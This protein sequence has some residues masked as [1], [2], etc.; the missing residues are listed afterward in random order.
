MTVQ[1]F[2]EEELQ[3][4]D[5]QTIIKLFLTTSAASQQMLEQQTSQIKQQASQ[6][7]QLNNNIQNL[8]AQLDVFK[9]Y[10]FGRR[11]ETG[12]TDAG[13]NQYSFKVNAYNELEVTLD[14]NPDHKEPAIEEIVPRAYTRKKAKGKRASDLSEIEKVVEKDT[15]SEEEL[16]KVFPDGKWTEFESYTYSRLHFFPAAF[17]VVEHHVMAYKGSGDRIVKANQKEPGLLRNSVATPSAVAAIMNYKFVNA[18]PIHRMQQELERMDVFLSS[19]DMCYWVNKCAD[20]YISRLYNVLH[21]KLFGYHVI[22]A[23]ETP[24]EVRKDGRAAGAKSY[25]WVY[26]SGALEDHPFVLYEYDKTRKTDHPRAFLKNY[27]G[28]VV[29]DGLSDYH[30]LDKER[31]DLTFAGCWVHFAEDVES[32]KHLVKDAK[33]KPAQPIEESNSY[34]A[35]LLIDTMAKYEREFAS[36]TPEERVKARQKKTAP[37]VDV[38]FTWMKTAS[39]Q[40]LPK[41]KSGGAIQYA[42]DEEKY[43]RVFLT[44]GYIPMDNNAAERGIRSF[45]IGRKNWY[46]IDTIHGAKSSAILYSIAETAKVNNL[47]PYEYFK[48][49]LEELPK[50]GEF[51]DDSYMEDLLP[52]SEKLPDYIRKKDQ[53]KPPKPSKT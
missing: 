50:H 34:K 27:H 3:N 33:G 52:W 45:T 36:M 13:E 39:M 25:M 31:D 23:D 37:L 38:F 49:L 41:S 24:V 7:E 43:L 20:M 29:T 8:T 35:L 32:L 21:R 12:M 42:L 5:K 44:D 51:E 14:E 30:L 4:L 9:K 16:L 2:T 11:T 10:L 22:H 15:L 19:Q 6:I 26:R 28:V 48:Y 40:T 18:V 53:P 47:K 1:S 17:K 46:L